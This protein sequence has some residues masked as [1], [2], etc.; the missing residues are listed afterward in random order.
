MSHLWKEDRAVGD[1]EPEWVVQQLDGW[2]VVPLGPAAG[3]LPP[4]PLPSLD[5][6]VVATNSES[7]VSGPGFLVS[8]Q[9]FHPSFLNQEPET[10]NSRPAPGICWAKPK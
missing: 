3:V 6:T 9:E 1:G 4:S 7:W 2:A 8:G 10:R 5:R